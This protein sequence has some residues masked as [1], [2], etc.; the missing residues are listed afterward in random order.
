MNKSVI[1]FSQFLDEYLN[2]ISVFIYQKYYNNLKNSKKAP[3]DIP[4]T[5]L[6][7]NELNVYSEEFREFNCQHCQ[8]ELTEFSISKEIKE[9]L[10]MK[11]DAWKEINYLFD[12][13]N[14]LSYLLYKSDLSMK[15][16]L[17]V[18]MYFVD[19]NYEQLNNE[20]THYLVSADDVKEIALKYMSRHR[21]NELV[22]NKS[23]T[24][25][26]N[27]DDEELTEEEL[28]F[29][30]EII[31]RAE[32]KQSSKELMI[33]CKA[34]YRHYRLKEDNLSDKDI[35]IIYKSLLILNIDEN[36]CDSIK[37]YLTEKKKKQ[38]SKN[39]TFIPEKKEEKVNTLSVKEQN[40]IY[41]EI[42]SMYNIDLERAVKPLN[43][44][45]IIYLV[46]LMYKLKISETKIRTAI[47]NIY[48]S[49]SV[50]YENPLAEFN[51]YYEKMVYLN[52]N[53][54]I[55]AALSYIKELIQ[56]MLMSDSK[57]YIE[58][59][60]ELKNTMASVKPILSLNIDFELEQGKNRI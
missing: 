2:D 20:S 34:I 31:K 26:L 13:F 53:E 54:D 11:T 45:E 3:G 6:D 25:I 39:I 35:E 28:N 57:S 43:L 23:F 15:E 56:E 29:R 10:D 24:S 42:M 16:R 8:D 47:K 18:I 30:D 50:S 12:K 1:K 36:I 44:D 7:L 14:K 41:R 21:Y 22:L 19:K 37:G 32:G 59:K 4:K 48:K 9:N 51:A 38:D 58:W 46:S 60:D 33:A 27:K 49:Y 17:D 40:K 52:E 55:K 5:T